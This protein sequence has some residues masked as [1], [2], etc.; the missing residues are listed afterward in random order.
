MTKKDHQ[1]FWQMK[2]KKFLWKR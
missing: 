2:I 1:K